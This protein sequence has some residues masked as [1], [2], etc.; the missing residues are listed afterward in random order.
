M[1]NIKK[2]V[3]QP[4]QSIGGWNKGGWLIAILVTNVN[5]HGTIVPLNVLVYILG[6]S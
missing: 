6:I 2:L 3:E 4:T 1:H 5:F